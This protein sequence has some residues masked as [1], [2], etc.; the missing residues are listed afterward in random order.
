MKILEEGK[1]G[2]AVQLFQRKGRNERIIPPPEQLDCLQ[3]IISPSIAFK[4]SNEPSSYLYFPQQA[5]WQPHCELS[6][7]IPMAGALALR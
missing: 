3:S 6:V 5:Q 1:V 7:S 4:H 2:K